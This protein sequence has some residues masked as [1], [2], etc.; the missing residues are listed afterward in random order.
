MYLESRYISFLFF[1]II[2]VLSY[3]SRPHV[4]FQFI[5]VLPVATEELSDFTT[6][7]VAMGNDVRTYVTREREEAAMSSGFAGEVWGV[8][9]LLIRREV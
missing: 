3:K 6:E 1:Q 7:C 4:S 9:Y 5:F 2:F 8:Q